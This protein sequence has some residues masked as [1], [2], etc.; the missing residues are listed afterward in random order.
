MA[1]FV[2]VF[3][4]RHLDFGFPQGCSSIGRALVSKTRGCEFETH[5]PCHYTN[6]SV[7]V[8]VERGWGG[9]WTAAQRKW[10]RF[11]ERQGGSHPVGAFF[12]E[13]LRVGIYKRSQGRITRQVTFAALAVVIALG[14]LRLSTISAR[15]RAALAVSPCRA[16]CCWPVLWA[17]YRMVNV[18]AFRRLPDCRR[19]RDEQGLLA[20][21]AG[22]VSRLDGGADRDFFLGDRLGGVRHSLGLLLPWGLHIL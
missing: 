18:P 7:G 1:T 10:S 8:T 20:H 13:M 21:A 11:N 16:C 14:L 6:T 2:R 9:S 4:I 17:A 3:V 22:V 12:Q 19:G 15:E 5:R